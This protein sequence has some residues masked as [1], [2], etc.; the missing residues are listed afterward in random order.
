MTSVA[1]FFVGLFAGGV[2]A[3]CWAMCREADEYEA[4]AKQFDEGLSQS[5]RSNDAVCKSI[6]RASNRAVRRIRQAEAID[7]ARAREGFGPRPF[8]DPPEFDDDDDPPGWG[9]E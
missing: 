5:M 3:W 1:A 8:Y 4:V 7:V 2:A 6:R 9:I